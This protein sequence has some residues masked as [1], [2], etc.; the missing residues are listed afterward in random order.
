M[1]ISY[2]FSK[3]KLLKLQYADSELDNNDLSKFILISQL[4]KVD[5]NKHQQFVVNNTILEILSIKKEEAIFL[6]ENIPSKIPK[7]AEKK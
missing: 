4:K 7:I 5:S 6:N 1:K 2:N 3:V